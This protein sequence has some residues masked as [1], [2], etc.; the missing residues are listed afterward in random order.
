[1]E[2]AMPRFASTDL[3]P[4]RLRVLA[5]LATLLVAA[6]AAPELQ[7]GRTAEA[8]QPGGPTIADYQRAF[9]LDDTKLR[10]LPRN[11]A[12]VPN[13]L[14]GG[15][16]FWFAHET[17][18][19]FEYFRVDSASGKREPLFD[20]AALR[21]AVNATLAASAESAEAPGNSK[22]GPN[23]APG[24]ALG[25]RI[26]SYDVEQQQ[27]T[28]TIN[29]KTLACTLQEPAC[30]VL[31]AAKPEPGLLLSPDGKFAA[32][33]RDHN[34]WLRE[35][36]TG[37]ERALT[38]DGEAYYAW[39]K[40]PDTSLAAIPQQRDQLV[41]PPY[42]AFWSPDGRK[43]VAT[44]MD[45]REVGIYPFVEWA[46]LDGSLRP[47]LYQLRVPLMGDPQPT[48]ESHVFDVASGTHSRIDPGEG[49]SVAP[50]SVVGWSANNQRLYMLA[51]SYG[52]TALRLLE[53]SRGNTR[54]AFEETSD[55]QAR[56]GPAAYNEPNVRLLR[57]GAEALW[58]SERTGWGHLYRIDLQSGQVLNALSS[59]D[60]T[61]HDI[62]RV[63][64][65]NGR[66]F[67]TAG[68][69]EP[70][71]PYQ[72]RLYRVNLDGSDL[73]LLTPEAADHE[74]PG[75]PS[76]LIRT[77]F[78]FPLPPD[79]ISPNGQFFV[80][81]YSTLQQPPVSV[82][83]STEDGRIIAE[84]QKADVSALVATGFRPPERFSATAADG[85]TT[86]W[87]ALYFPP[88]FDPAKSYPV[89]NALY[90][91]PQVSIAPFNYRSAF[92]G[93]GQ[94]NR[95]A[96][97][98]LGFIVVTVDGRGTPYRSLEFQ[99][100]SRGAGH[101]TETLK[102][103]RAAI[104]QLAAAR[105]YMDITRVGVYGHSWGGYHT[106]LAILQHND[107][108]DAAV[109][110]AGLYGYQ[111]SYGGFENFVGLPDYG[112]GSTLRPAPDAV[113]PNI[114]A[115]SVPPLAGNLK[116]GHLMLAY[117]DADENV[118][119]SQAV[120]LIDALIKADRDFDLLYLPNRTH[121]YVPEPY[122]QR[123]LWDYMVRH[124]MGVEPPDYSI[125]PPADKP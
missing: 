77:V 80:E 24:S 44:R 9:G 125:L 124:A 31:E 114:A 123:R 7:P 37:Q 4:G 106:A 67:F 91:G 74:L 23:S 19:G 6:C 32:F 99:N 12:T 84:L 92:S 71:D 90:A 81:E 42:A 20:H 53:I 76:F 119:P 122:F 33:T 103:H 110:S 89:I 63:D 49:F 85:I 8:P 109:A 41:K 60:W 115:I 47:K 57:D 35:L 97:A 52:S 108:Y 50:A 54:V 64:E 48:L 65:A 62:L 58:F 28:G 72:R 88:D 10:T 13:W 34:I 102:D 116:Q 96:L 43:L 61:V 66:V 117:G 22:S 46:P 18:S 55:T 39:G 104:E 75:A 86:I 82:L 73:A 38:H 107:F 69:R 94:Y 40:V 78:G 2:I 100:A 5:G 87:G 105:P 11:A 120:Q 36:A 51:A 98:S 79:R 3:D 15:E 26:S 111:W 17:E 113:A 112:N 59:G 101:G 83:R 95:T 121:Y 93:L 30:K 21:A 29:G 25:L 27:V 68:G 1:M 45:E 16:A 56:L 118:Q 70:G 14:D